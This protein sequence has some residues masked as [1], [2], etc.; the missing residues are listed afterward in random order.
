MSD[1]FAN[2]SL[3]LPLNRM[4]VLDPC[5]LSAPYCP[6]RDGESMRCPA[7]GNGLV[8]AVDALKLQYPVKGKRLLTAF[9]GFDTRVWNDKLSWEFT[10]FIASVRL[11]ICKGA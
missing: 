6:S 10:F 1:T 4:G 11:R 9:F 8:D 2:H 5:M 7:D 3:T